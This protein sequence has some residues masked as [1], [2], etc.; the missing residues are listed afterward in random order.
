ML[1]GEERILPKSCPQTVIYQKYQRTAG[2][3]SRDCNPAPG[4]EPPQSP[5]EIQLPRDGRERSLARNRSRAR[6]HPRPELRLG[7]HRALDRVGG[8]EGEVIRR[9]RARA[10]QRTLP[11]PQRPRVR[12]HV[13]VVVI[14]AQ[15]ELADKLFG[16]EPGG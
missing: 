11:R 15:Q 8:K 14:A 1:V 7:L 6:R 13:V 16:A 5:R 12:V 3:G 2:H 10:A 9:A 4:I